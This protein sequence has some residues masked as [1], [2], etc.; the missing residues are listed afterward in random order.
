MSDAIQA[1]AEELD[2]T[3]AVSDPLE[4]MESIPNGAEDLSDYESQIENLLTSAGDGGE[5]EEPEAPAPEPEP[6][7]EPE[8]LEEPAEE[9]ETE[10]DDESDEEKPAS[11]RFRVRAKDDVEAEALSLRKRHPDWSLEKCLTSA[12]SILGVDS[13]P[14]DEPADDE[15]KGEPETVANITAQLREL[16]EQ[17]AQAYAALEIEQ[18]AEVDKLMDELRDRREEIRVTEAQAKQE[19]ATREQEQFE[20]AY[21]KSERLTATYYPDATDPDSAL[22]KKMIE[23]DARMRELGDPLYDSPEKPFTLAKMAAR[24]LQIPMAQVNGTKPAAAKKTAP[25]NPAPGNRGTS[26]AVPAARLEQAIDGLETLEDYE[27][28]V[29]VS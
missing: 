9:E 14:A 4:D 1:Q 24:E 29:G 15:S 27:K 26:P 21:S 18:V 23:M 25:F 13:T 28:F 20:S 7:A 6:E 8:P 22:T 3:P 16:A 17:K 10:A 2:T 19:K 5:D 12:K 11:N